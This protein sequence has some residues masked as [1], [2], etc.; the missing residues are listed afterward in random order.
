MMTDSG[1]YPPFA[2]FKFSDKGEKKS[3]GKILTPR[4]CAQGRGGEREGRVERRGD[5]GDEGWFRVSDAPPGEKEK[6]KKRK[7]KN[8]PGSTGECWDDF[9][10]IIPLR[11]TPTSNQ[12]SEKTTFPLSP[13][14]DAR[15]AAGELKG[16]GLE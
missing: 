7:N 11:R 9:G 8:S 5:G 16:G 2:D 13:A 12:K 3:A 1:E 15:C 6:K 4:C 14:T 10:E